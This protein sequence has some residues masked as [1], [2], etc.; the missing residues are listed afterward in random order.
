MALYPYPVTHYVA[1]KRNN[2][3][4]HVYYRKLCN[5]FHKLEEMQ[6]TELFAQNGPIWHFK[7]IFIYLDVYAESLERYVE[8]T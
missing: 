8:Y 7:K 1:S 4:L 3:V 2:L 5:M 6:S